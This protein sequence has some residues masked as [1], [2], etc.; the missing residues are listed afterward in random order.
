[1]ANIGRNRKEC[2]GCLF[3]YCRL[4]GL[5]GGLNGRGESH[6]NF[7]LSGSNTGKIS[8]RVV[9]AAVDAT[10]IRLLPLR[11]RDNRHET[12]RQ[13]ARDNTQREEIKSGGQ[14]RSPSNDGRDDENPDRHT[15]INRSQKLTGFEGGCKGSL[16]LRSNEDDG[17][18]CWG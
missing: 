15:S 5:F 10:V 12:T 6:I 18:L 11:R 17:V 7:W 13:Q 16:Q 14:E 1:M 8:T 9:E 2:V 3:A 4:A